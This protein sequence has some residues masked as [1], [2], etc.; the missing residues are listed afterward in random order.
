[1]VPD[2]PQTRVAAGLPTV[3]TQPTAEMEEA[4]VLRWP[5][6]C[7]P[8]AGESGSGFIDR[9]VPLPQSERSA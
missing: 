4:T 5:T 2:G 9:G 7:P 6:A 1:V 3:D 8:L